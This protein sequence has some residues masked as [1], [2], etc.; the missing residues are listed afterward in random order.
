LNV[1]NHA[2]R[3]V[4]PIAISPHFLHSIVLFSAIRPAR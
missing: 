2:L 3:H 4:S 1:Q